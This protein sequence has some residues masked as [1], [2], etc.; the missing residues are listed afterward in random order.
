MFSRFACFARFCKGAISLVELLFKMRA[1]VHGDSN[2]ENPSMRQF[3]CTNAEIRFSLNASSMRLG[4]L[5]FLSSSMLKI[6]FIATFL[7]RNRR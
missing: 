4:Q 2:A 1:I 7:R 6:F 3:P 5:E